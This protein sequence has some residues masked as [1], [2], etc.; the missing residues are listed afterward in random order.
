[1][2]L[3]PA[4]ENSFI[5][6]HSPDVLKMKEHFEWNFLWYVNF[7][8]YYVLCVV[9]SICSSSISV[10]ISKYN[11]C[12]LSDFL[13]FLWSVGIFMLWSGFPGMKT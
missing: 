5:K 11:I 8:M 1:M 6:T 2:I 3:H 4:Y 7:Q 9:L 13:L 10:C 12:V